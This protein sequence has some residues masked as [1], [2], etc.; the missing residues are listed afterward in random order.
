MPR[1]KKN[2]GDVS[3]LISMLRAAIIAQPVANQNRPK[4]K[5]RKKRSPASRMTQTDP[6][7]MMISRREL[8]AEVTLA[9]TKSDVYGMVELR[10]DKFH[11]LKGLA[12]SFERFRFSKMRIYWKPAVGTTVGGMVGLGVDWDF[13]TTTSNQTRADISSYTPSQCFA[14]WADTEPKPLVL[15]QNRLQSR[16]WYLTSG[17]TFDGG[18]ALLKYAASGEANASSARTL[19]EIWVDYTVQ[20]SGTQP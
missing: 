17:T 10:P 19:G 16:P 13:S 3:Q 20:F 18:V 1:K 15:P 14:V 8:I 6:G 11:F 2:S 4:A 9:A 12:K 7:G 5:K